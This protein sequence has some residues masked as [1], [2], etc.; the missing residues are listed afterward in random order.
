LHSL[1]PN[2]VTANPTGGAH[3]IAIVD[4]YHYP[5]AVS[6][7]AVFSA[8][9]LLPQA[10]LQV[11]FANGQRPPVNDL[12]NAVSVAS[13]LVEAAGGGEVSMSWGGSEFYG[14]SVIRFAIYP[15]RSCL[16]RSLR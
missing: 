3:A 13:N 9:F 16:F 1:D 12:L 6:D 10:K 8:Q 11:V 2:T 14:E 15:T 5:T 7:L 4:A